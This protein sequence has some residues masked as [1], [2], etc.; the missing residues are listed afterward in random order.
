MANL[1]SFFP[2][3]VSAP[4]PAGLTKDPRFLPLV[5]ASTNVVI[6]G[7]NAIV[8]SFWTGAAGFGNAGA[9]R[10]TQ[11]ANAWGTIADITGRG[12]LTHV[13]AP[14][15]GATTATVR[16]RLT[17]DGVEYTIS[18]AG[19]I[20]VLS[21]GRMLIGCAD[22]T[23]GS[24]F[25][26]ADGVHLIRFGKP[27]QSPST[28]FVNELATAYL[29]QPWRIYEHGMPCLYFEESLKVET[30]VSVLGTGTYAQYS[31]CAYTI[32]GGD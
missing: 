32:L 16:F 2:S 20:S 31:A 8:P 18:K 22:L 19:G 3:T 14:Q 23:G 1:S 10:T 17:V 24:S 9:V 26:A 29:Y 7:N 4:L 6:N 25:Y 12:M 30:L 21:D 13:V 11:T 15:H 5:D 28:K 27:A